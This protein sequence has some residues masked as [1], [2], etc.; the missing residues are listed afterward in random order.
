MKASKEV[1]KEGLGCQ[2]MSGRF[3]IPK[4]IVERTMHE[5]VIVIVKLQW[6][7]QEVRDDRNVEH[8]FMKAS[9]SHHVHHL[10]NQL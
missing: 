3:E 10:L 6:I 5:V 1:S 7:P 9:N 4:G 8:L 2:A